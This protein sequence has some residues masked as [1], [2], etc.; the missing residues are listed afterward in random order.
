MAAETFE[1]CRH[2][3]PTAPGGHSTRPERRVA[4]GRFGRPPLSRRTLNRASSGASRSFTPSQHGGATRPQAR[5]Q[6]RH[7][8]RSQRR[9]NQ[10]LPCAN[11]RSPICTRCSPRFGVQ[12][13]P[14]KT[15]KCARL[16]RPWTP[17]R[18]RD[19]RN[20]SR[21][22]R[23]D[24]PRPHRPGT[25]PTRTRWRSRRPMPQGS[26]STC[27]PRIAA[28]PGPGTVSGRHGSTPTSHRAARGSR[29]RTRLKNSRGARMRAARGPET[30]AVGGESGPQY[31]PVR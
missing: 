28:L 5:A 24:R 15:R 16:S 12:L 21:P 10:P 19:H 11:T 1:P 20:G 29:C 2:R 17:P 9:L 8:P 25:R 6:T 30:C 27:T 4:R 13:R 14:G 22:S 18:S 7:C 23:A 3:N 26:S 31:R